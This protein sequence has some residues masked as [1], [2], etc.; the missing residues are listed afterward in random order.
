MLLLS[1]LLATHV[2]EEQYLRCK[3][4]D[5]LKER[6]VSSELLSVTQKMDL[7]THWMNQTD[8]KCFE[9]KE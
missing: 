6:A 7:I 5:W 1:L 8:P 3:D 2:P 4:Y 9:D